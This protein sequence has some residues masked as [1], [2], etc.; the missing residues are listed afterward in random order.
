MVK[1]TYEVTA[2]I[3]VKV[4]EVRLL[5]EG[6]HTDRYFKLHMASALQRKIDR[7]LTLGPGFEGRKGY[8]MRANLDR[9]LS[10]YDIT[11]DL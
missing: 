11:D 8:R 9:V 7:D 2:E 6:S 10:W 5:V 1:R 4:E 3:T